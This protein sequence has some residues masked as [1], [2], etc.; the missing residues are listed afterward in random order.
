M[1]EKLNFE[2]FY[3]HPPERVWKALTDPK[4]LAE[5]LLPTDFRPILGLRFRFD[6]HSRGSKVE[7]EVVGV[8]EAKL[9]QYTWDDGEAGSPSVVTWSLQPKDGGTLVHLE[10]TSSVAAEPYVVIEANLNWRYA[11]YASLPVL[12]G[13]MK[14]GAFRPPVPITYVTE[15]PK[16]ETTRRAGFRQD[17]EAAC[18]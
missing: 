2:A 14:T 17:E 18:R 11:L 15:E 4:A 1:N 12:L 3:P 9:L 7:G 16:E 5:W 10:H 6:G 13:L 8:E